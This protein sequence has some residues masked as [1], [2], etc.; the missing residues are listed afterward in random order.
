V[1]LVYAGALCANDARA[2]Q[3]AI[4]TFG[5]ILDEN[6][7]RAGCAVNILEAQKRHTVPNFAFAWPNDFNTDPDTGWNVLIFRPAQQLELLTILCAPTRLTITK[8][9]GFATDGAN[10]ELAASMVRPARRKIEGAT[11]TPVNT[12]EHF[13]A[14]MKQTVRP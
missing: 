6:T 9:I 5:K 1:W 13:Y 10:K 2:T 7:I 8:N 12:S 3:R 11:R 14:S 4:S